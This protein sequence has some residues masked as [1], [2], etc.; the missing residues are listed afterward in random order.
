M[1]I[2][3]KGVSNHVGRHHRTVEYGRGKAYGACGVKHHHYDTG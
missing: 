2:G 3:R 1:K